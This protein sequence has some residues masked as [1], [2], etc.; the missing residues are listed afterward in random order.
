MRVHKEH[1]L[2]KKN[3]NFVPATLE[4]C[5]KTYRQRNALY[6]NNYKR[7]GHI[8]A[9]MFPNGISLKTPDDF[10]RFGVFVQIVSKLTRYCAQ[11]GEGGHKDS[12]LDEA[13]YSVMMH[14]VD[15]EA[16]HNSNKRKLI[17]S[18]EAQN[19]NNINKR[20]RSNSRKQTR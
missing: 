7:F 19:G 4:A 2:K 13:V 14:E 18:K 20:V 5:A 3:N 10:N 1:L 11:Y 9:Q 17:K 16:R 12:L 8:M 15:N 6:G